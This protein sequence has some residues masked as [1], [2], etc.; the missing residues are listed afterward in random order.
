MRTFVGTVSQLRSVAITTTQSG[1]SSTRHETSIRFGE[2]SLNL[3]TKAAPSIHLGDQLRVYGV[4]VGG[5]VWPILLRNE[6]NSYEAGF[7][8]LRDVIVP[9][10]LGSALLVVSLATRSAGWAL[11]GLAFFAGAGSVAAIR[12]VAASAMR[13]SRAAGEA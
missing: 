3:K 12:H 8:S 6:Q 5:S 11:L 1:A 9:S 13:R 10:V 2:F 7:V 4:Q